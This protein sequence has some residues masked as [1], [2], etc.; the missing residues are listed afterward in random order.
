MAKVWRAVAE[1]K[2]NVA[3]MSGL[4]K[5]NLAVKEAVSELLPAVEKSRD[6]RVFAEKNALSVKMELSF[7]KHREKSFCE[8][9]AAINK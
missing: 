9:K 8:A 1:D 7:I 4:Q 5:Q 6:V 3:V 2:G